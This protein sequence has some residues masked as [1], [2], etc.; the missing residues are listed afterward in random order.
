MKIGLQDE[1]VYKLLYVVEKRTR[2]RK[3]KVLH[4]NTTE[5]VFGKKKAGHEAL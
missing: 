3:H 1:E 5:L 4:K 2:N